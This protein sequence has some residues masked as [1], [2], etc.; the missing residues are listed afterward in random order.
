LG[1]AQK[2]VDALELHS[3]P[4]H[5]ELIMDGGA[6]KVIEIAA[7]IGGFREKM[8]LTSLGVS[9]TEADLHMQVF[10][11]PELIPSSKIKYTAALKV[12]ALEEGLLK[13]IENLELIEN[14]EGHLY[15]RVKKSEGEMVGPSRLGYSEVL[16]A[17]IA[18]ESKEDLL[19]VSNE[20]IDKVKANIKK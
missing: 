3:C 8:Y 14:S 19:K 16:Y 10:D 17:Y 7:R 6:P 5:A 15:S 1:C 20:I 12:Y 11:T 13:E 9:L 2:A 18:N 4:I